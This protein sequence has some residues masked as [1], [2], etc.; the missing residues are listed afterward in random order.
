MAFPNRFLETGAE[1]SG[2]RS[3]GEVTGSAT[4]TNPSLCGRGRKRHRVGGGGS[5][6]KPTNFGEKMEESIGN[7]RGILEGHFEEMCGS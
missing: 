1:P 2:P 4:A 7:L 6:R 5:R 3:N